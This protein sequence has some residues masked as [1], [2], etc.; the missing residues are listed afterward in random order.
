MDANLIGSIEEEQHPGC[1]TIRFPIA[2]T[3]KQVLVENIGHVHL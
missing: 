3:A 1:S 2:E